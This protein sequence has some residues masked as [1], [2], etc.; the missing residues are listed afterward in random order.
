MVVTEVQY[1][2]NDILISQ[3]ELYN[4]FPAHIFPPSERI[5]LVSS[6]IQ[7]HVLQKTAI[8]GK[9]KLSH[10]TCQ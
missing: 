3:I 5:L 9:R 4:P 8:P 7:Q 6:F 2:G 10:S 1:I